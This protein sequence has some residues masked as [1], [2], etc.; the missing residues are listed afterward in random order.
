MKLNI[1]RMYLLKNANK[2]DQERK[3]TTLFFNTHSFI[4]ICF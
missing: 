4:Y 2:K 3:N 1:E